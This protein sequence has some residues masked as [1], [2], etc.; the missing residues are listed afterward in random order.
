MTTIVASISETDR[1]MASVGV[2]QWSWDGHNRKLTMDPCCKGLFE[3]DW[4]QTVSQEAIL[5]KIHEDDRQRYLD[6]IRSCQE[7]GTFSCEFRVTR[8]NGKIRYLSG[9]GH[10]VQHEDDVYVV[11]GVFIDVTQAKNLEVQLTRTRSRM[12]DLV[13]GIPGLFSYIDTEYHVQFMSSKYRDVFNLE[14]NSELVGVHIKELIGE[15]MFAERKPRYDEALAGETVNFEATRVMPDGT[16]K[17]LAVAHQPHRDAS[18]NIIGVITLGIDVTERREME[19]QLEAKQEELVRS[20]KDLEQFAYVA[21]HDLKAP[22]RAIE[23]LVEW[24]KDDLEDYQEGDVQ[25]NLDLL[26]TRTGRLA[27][28]LDDL[29][30]YSRAGRK[31]GD[32]RD[33]NLKEFVSDVAALIAPPTGFQIVADDSLD[34]VIPAH[35]APLETVLRNLMNNAIKHHPEPEKGLIHVYAKDNGDSVMFGVLDNGEGIPEEYSEKIFKMFQTLQPRDEKEGS[36]MGLAIVKRI[37]DWQGGRIWYGAGPEGK[38]TVFK[39]T[40][41][42]RPAEMPEVVSEEDKSDERSANEAS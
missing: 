38:G 4:D 21:S 11:K 12:Q 19:L 2:G 22:L 7:E 32:V 35:H 36:G 14:S 33:V 17:M 3:V 8:N 39:F 16:E 25:E 10:I 40:W 28:L 23:V 34:V 13:D 6:A 37:I 26:E 29:L 18:G 30:A 15:E 1:L 31:I 9:R 20:N 24:L 41:N 27:R 42:K 5:E